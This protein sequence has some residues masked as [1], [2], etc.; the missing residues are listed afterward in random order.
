MGFSF[1]MVF[2]ISIQ[3]STLP[4]KTSC[5]WEKSGGISFLMTISFL[6][7]CYS[8]KN[9]FSNF[10]IVLL[11]NSEGKNQKSTPAVQ[12][13]ENPPSLI[14]FMLIF[15][16]FRYIQFR[17]DSSFLNTSIGSSSCLSINVHQLSEREYSPLNFE[18]ISLN[19]SKLY[20][21][22]FFPRQGL[23]FALLLSTFLISSLRTFRNSL[24]LILWLK[25]RCKGVL[26]ISTNLWIYSNYCF[27]LLSSSPYLFSSLKS[28]FRR[29]LVLCK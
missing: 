23:N 15:S 28:F 20:M 17:T 7:R 18:E 26:L 9:S 19:I 22:A 21:S 6:T 10:D 4:L 25:G 1:L 2:S 3:C 12:I 8:V 24:F 29:C 13:S 27:S 16:F 5:F 14:F 11:T